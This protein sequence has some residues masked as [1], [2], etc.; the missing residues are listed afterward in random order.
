MARASGLSSIVTQPP[1]RQAGGSFI[2]SHETREYPIPRSHQAPSGQPPP[3]QRTGN[4]ASE[5]PGG[6]GQSQNIRNGSSDNPLAF[7]GF[8]E[9]IGSTSR[10]RDIRAEVQSRANL[11][12]PPQNYP[13]EYDRFRDAQGYNREGRLDHV[14]SHNFQNPISSKNQAADYGRHQSRVR[15]LLVRSN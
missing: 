6:M 4:S 15:I 8:H 5:G 3:W 2:K 12:L 13:R 1:W 7:T 14:K 9:N 10:K 11:S